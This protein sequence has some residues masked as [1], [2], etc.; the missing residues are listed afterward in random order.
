MTQVDTKTG[1]PEVGDRV[2]L[3]G[4]HYTVKRVVTHEDGTVEA[5]GPLGKPLGTWRRVEVI[6]HV[7]PKK[8]PDKRKR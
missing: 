5:W 2:V 3:S 6:E 1:F 8:E 4:F 7:K